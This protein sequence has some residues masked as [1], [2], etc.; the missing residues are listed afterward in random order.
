MKPKAGSVS[1]NPMTPT[2]STNEMSN[3]SDNHI[4]AGGSSSGLL[5]EKL[6]SRSSL[7]GS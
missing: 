3:A 7:T 5:K 2:I 1:E 6:S 4:H